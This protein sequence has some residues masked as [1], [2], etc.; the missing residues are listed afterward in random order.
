MITKQH[1]G[2]KYY[3]IEPTIEIRRM[4]LTS[5]IGVHI[6]RRSGY[7]NKKKTY[8]PFRIHRWVQNGEL[9]TKVSWKRSIPQ[10]WFRKLLEHGYIFKTKSECISKELG[11][12]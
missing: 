4:W 8:I 6:V 5:K 9:N 11:T 12:L 1:Q 10:Q 7:W 2:I 3:F